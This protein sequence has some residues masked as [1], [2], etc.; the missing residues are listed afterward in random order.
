[1]KYSLNQI[2][3]YIPEIAA[4]P[5]AELISRIWTSIAEVEH[6]EYL[7]KKYEGVVVAKVL[8]VENHPK[9]EKLVLVT[10]DVGKKEPVLVVTAA[11]NCK[12]GD[13]V[14]YIPDGGTVPVGTDEAGNPIVIEVRAMGG[15]PSVGMLASEREMGVSDDHTGIMILAPEEL[16]KTLVVGEAAAIPLE[17]DDVVFEIENKSLTHRGDCFS[18]MGIAR[19]IATMYGLKL[20]IPE[21]QIPSFGIPALMGDS[22]DREFTCN[23]KVTV[24]ATPVI[25]RYSAIVLDG[26][27]VGPS[28]LWLRIFL[29]KHGVNAVNNVVDVANYVMVDY[30]QPMHAFD[31]ATISHKKRDELTEYEIDVRYAKPGEILLTL[32]GKEKPLPSTVAV[33]ADLKKALAVAGIIGGMES[34]TTENST[35]IVLESAVFNKYAIRK[36]SMTIGKVTDGSVVYS[37]KQDSEKTVRGLLRAVHLLK[38]LAGARVASSIADVYP[39]Q[40]LSTSIVV[41]HQKIEDF[42]GIA[43]S[44]NAVVQILE[45]LGCKVVK[46]NGM[47]RIETPTWRP[48]IAIDEDVYEEIA[49]MIGYNKIP[50]ELPKR[51]IFGVSLAPYENFKLA[52]LQSLTSLGLTQA[53]NFSFVSELLYERCQIPLEGARAITNAI[54]PDVQYVRKHIE[55]GL[56]EQLAKNQYYAD[57]FG[58][59]EIGKTSRLGLSYT[60]VS[61]SELHMPEARFGV[62]EL[63]LP[64]EDEHIAIGIIDDSAQ[65]GFYVIKNS[66]GKYL[67][68]LQIDSTFVHPDDYG[69]KELKKLPQWVLE[70]LSHYKR[71]RVALVLHARTNDFL[72]I[73]GEPGTMTSKSFGITKS[74]AT[75]ELSLNKIFTHVNLE[76]LHREPSKYPT[77]TEDLCFEV[78]VGMAYGAVV[79]QFEA[80]AKDFADSFL[81]TVTVKDIYQKKPTTKQITHRIVFSP[82]KE[83]LTDAT[84]KLYRTKLEAAM[85]KIGASLI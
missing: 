57:R 84:M 40:R 16:R 64:I 5:V 46:K 82:C 49:R 6:V 30:G 77:V 27:Q 37:R 67:Q 73:I 26:L 2:K 71:G 75:A 7:E 36:A 9:S 25:E 80:V 28:P 70:M 15:I 1:M 74:L 32:D 21:W 35:R 44:P 78:P 41:S 79:S 54:S 24:S 10:V 17:F 69:A 68:S 56:V 65:P 13:F 66:V 62:D 3:R 48:D 83:S 23:V 60:G 14:P 12:K 19:E 61:V 39:E 63:G 53:M 72:G 47:Y 81:L 34:S 42:L 20:V 4:V 33:I 58:L 51:G 8:S 55:P 31:A 85:K 50:S 38:E 59:F 18:D 22:F 43:V 45:G 52:T 29:M 11:H 76:P